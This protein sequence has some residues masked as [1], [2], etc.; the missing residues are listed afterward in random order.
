MPTYHKLTWGHYKV[1]VR[2]TGYRRFLHFLPYF[3]GTNIN[4]VLTVRTSSN[5]KREFLYNWFLRRFD[6]KQEHLLIQD[7]GNCVGKAQYKITEELTLPYFSYPDKYTLQVS[8]HDKQW[9][10]KVKNL[11]VADFTIIDRDT[12][13]MK[14]ITG[15][16]LAILGA[17]I[18]VIVL[19]ITNIIG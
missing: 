2:P 5:E 19:L 10:K 15:I 3:T 17:F 8:I 4:L 14:F 9:N 11:V 16:L 1:S 12:I 7:G 13:A 18:T 6:G